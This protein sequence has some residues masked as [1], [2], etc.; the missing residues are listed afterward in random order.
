MG[1][2]FSFAGERESLPLI[3]KWQTNLQ[4]EINKM[5]KK[6]NG[7][8]GLYVKDLSSDL[9]FSVNADVPWYLSST[10][11]LPIAVEVFKN[12]Q[13]KTLSLKSKLFIFLGLFIKV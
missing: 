9:T 5:T 2:N 12:I 13:Q 7:E 4:T 10:V 3:P 8:F 11:K 6:F 1:P